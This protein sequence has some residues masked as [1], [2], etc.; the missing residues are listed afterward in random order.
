MF[1]QKPAGSQRLAV[2]LSYAW[3]RSEEAGRPI[4]VKIAAAELKGMAKAANAVGYGHTESH[5]YQMVQDFMG[6]NPKP[7]Y[8]PTNGAARIAWEDKAAEILGSELEASK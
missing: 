1:N 8:N 7:L 3:V 2:R 4:D 5:V 6:S